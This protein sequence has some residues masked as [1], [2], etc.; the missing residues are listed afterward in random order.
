M[1]MDIYAEGPLGVYN[2]LSI[3]TTR[4]LSGGVNPDYGSHPS[5]LMQRA[6]SK[7]GGD[8]WSGSMYYHDTPSSNIGAPIYGSP[9]NTRLS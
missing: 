8:I 6:I 9:N 1:V 5:I 3:E 7:P 4:R 2:T